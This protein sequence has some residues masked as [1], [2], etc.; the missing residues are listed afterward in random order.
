MAG[1]P[2]EEKLVPQETQSPEAAAARKRLQ[3]FLDELNPAGGVLDDGDGS[4]RHMN[5]ERVKGKKEKRQ[6]KSSDEQEE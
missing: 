3:S 4:G 6:S 5:Q 1:A 2:F